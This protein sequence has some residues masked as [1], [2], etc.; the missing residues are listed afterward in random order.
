[1]IVFHVAHTHAIE[2]TLLQYHINNAIW[3]R[4]S[5]FAEVTDWISKTMNIIEQKSNILSLE[6]NEYYFESSLIQ[7]K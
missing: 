5:Y 7:L 4:V 2:N 1:M 3:F 6:V